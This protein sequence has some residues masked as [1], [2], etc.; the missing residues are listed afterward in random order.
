MVDVVQVLKID[1][2]LSLRRHLFEF[3]RQS[4]QA[5]ERRRPVQVK[6]RPPGIGIDPQF[7]GQ[8]REGVEQFGRCQCDAGDDAGQQIGNDDCDHGHRVDRH[9][10]PAVIEKFLDRL[11][12][13]QL[14]ARVDQDRSKGRSRNQ[15]QQKGQEN[16]EQQQPHAVQ[17]RR[18]PRLSSGLDVGG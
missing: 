6:R 4:R 12:I 13:H 5:Y 18:Q 16:D 1:V 14:I 7:R 15:P 11:G 9:L 17:N 2:Q 3:A 10:A 8:M